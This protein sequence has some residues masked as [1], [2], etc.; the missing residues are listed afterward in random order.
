MDPFFEGSLPLALAP[1]A[2]GGIERR[3]EIVA[4]GSGREARNAVWAHGRRRYDLAGAIATLDDIAAVLAFF[5]ARRGR[6]QG[7][8][9]RDAT[10]CRSCEPS[11]SPAPTD[12]AI[13]M[14]DGARTTFQLVRTYGAGADAYVR[15]VQKP[16]ADSVR[17]AVGGAE[18]SAAL[19]S[20]AP[21]TG[22][23]TFADPP[24]PGAAITAGYLFDTPVRFDADRLETRMDGYGAGRI[25]SVP[26]VEV[27]V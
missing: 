22:V 26:L 25:V 24:A 13:G 7:F 3:T 21:A 9:F 4:L 16:V 17:V 11:R 19:V 10:D 20:V 1:G 15:S 14:G 6:L 12:Q 23:V 5:E 27:A 8:R 18:V 2:G